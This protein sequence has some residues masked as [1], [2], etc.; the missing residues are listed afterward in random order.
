M[1]QLKFLIKRNVKLFFKDKGMLITSLITPAILL[2]LYVTF[3]GNVYED[4]F[5]MSLNGA[6]LS[7]K[8]LNGAVGG[9]L[10]SS[11][12]SVSCVT[13][14]FSSNLLMVQDIVS[15]ARKD[16][17]VSP[18]KKTT[19]SLGYFISTVISSMTVCMVA[20]VGGF[21]YLAVT[22]WF[23]SVTD[24]LLVIL[25]VF[26]IVIFGTALSSII[27]CF[28]TTQGQMSAVGTIV[29]SCYGFIC[30][31]YMPLSQLGAGFRNVVSF[32]PGTYATT[33]VRN[34]CLGGVFKEM[35]NSGIPLEAIKS[36]KD[37]VDANFYFFGSS[38]PVGVMFAV[39]VSSAV[40]LTLAYVLIAVKK[41]K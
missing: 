29:S 20:V 12:L 13:V 32:L 14:S 11:L 31:A 37:G 2:V 5:L 38:V 35:Q 24:V 36:L 40:L 7:K 16:F 10:V 15:G 25:D 28:L 18:I 39:V 3:L 17:T 23:L 8:V 6:P 33:L 41:S 22:G 34:H 19:L 26:L 4:S 27:N 1:T 21:I 30:G 9:Q